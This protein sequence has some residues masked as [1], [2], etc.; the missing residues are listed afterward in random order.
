MTSIDDYNDREYVPHALPR[1]ADGR[2]VG[3][4]LRQLYRGVRLNRR[5]YAACWHA[6]CAENREPERRGCYGR[7][8]RKKQNK[9]TL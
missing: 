2:L 5:D 1:D 3:L 4:N 7:G 8:R 6:R 9:H